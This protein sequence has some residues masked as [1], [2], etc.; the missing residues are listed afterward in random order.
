MASLDAEPSVKLFDG[1]A[2]DTAA[3]K[4]Y[5]LMTVTSFV[6][7]HVMNEIPQLST[8]APTSNELCCR[9]CGKKYIRPSFLKQH[10]ERQ[11]GHVGQPQLLPTTS[12]AKEDYVYNYTHNVLVLPLLRRN[13]N[14]AIHL[15]DG[16]RVINFYKFFYLFYKISNCPKY[17]YAT[18]E[19]LA[20]VNCLLSPRMAYSLT[21][22]RTVNHK[23]KK[24]TNHSMDLDL[25]HDNK[26]FKTD[27][28]TSKGEITDKTITRIS[29]STASA[30]EILL[31]YDSNTAVRRLSG[32]HTRQ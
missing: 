8:D 29:R 25:E 24:D 30:D 11:H 15:G 23:G 28:H 4:A 22:N 19:L 7:K 6:E 3:K 32:R 5:V 9:Y 31:N 26:S 27:G 17:V 1:P 21:W 13:H 12:T 2:T 16:A 20:Q 10:E 18:V 14:D